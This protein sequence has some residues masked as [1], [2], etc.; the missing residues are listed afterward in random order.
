MEQ[1]YNI[2][3]TQGKLQLNVPTSNIQIEGK[4]IEGKKKPTCLPSNAIDKTEFST[5]QFN[6]LSV[7]IAFFTDLDTV[8]SSISFV[9]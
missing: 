5:S 2:K 4:K 7:S 1:L 9:T 3:G 6:N 8:L